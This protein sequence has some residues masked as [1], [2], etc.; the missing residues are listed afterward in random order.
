MISI[1]PI[2]VTVIFIFHGSRTVFA[3]IDCDEDLI[4]KIAK[5]ANTL[6]V[7]VKQDER[8]LK[9]LRRFEEMDDIDQLR[10]YYYRTVSE[11]IQTKCSFIKR[12]GGHW[13]SKC[14][15]LEDEKIACFDKF[16][17]QVRRSKCLVYSFGVGNHWDFE[18]F[19]AKI[20]CQV[21]VF[22]PL[23]EVPEKI[24]KNTRIS[25]DAIAIGKVKANKN[26]KN[27]NGNQS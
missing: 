12:I 24:K 18:E 25:V 14:G 21:R 26:I 10:D 19:M 7:L 2:I 16:E 20:G 22:D 4:N 27:V 13:K 5:W 3:K 17:H 9:N 11:T 6:P 1:F 23:V 8:R 15:F